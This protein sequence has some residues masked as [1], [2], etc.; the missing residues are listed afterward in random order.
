MAEEPFAPDPKKQTPAGK[1]PTPPA[2]DKKDDKKPVIP[3]TGTLPK[4]DKHVFIIPN[5]PNTRFDEENF[6]VLLEGS[7]SLTM[8]EK[9]RVIEA[10][11]RL[12]IEQINE[13][14]K[15]FEEEKQKFAELE[16][17]FKDDVEKLK[18][19]RTKEMEMTEKIDTMK[20]EENAEAD[21]EAAEAAAL[22]AKLMKDG[23]ADD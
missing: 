13:L 22:K 14:I 11:P 5:H 18:N 3:G 7:I 21:D 17:E 2:D 12:A 8:E 20:K 15:I 1:N 9:K 10:I 6:L 4:R 23:V 19:E 16:G